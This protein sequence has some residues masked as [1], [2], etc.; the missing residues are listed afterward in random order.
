MSHE[1]MYRG[2]DFDISKTF[3][4]FALFAVTG[5]KEQVIDIADIA[6]MEVLY[7]VIGEIINKDFAVSQVRG[8]L[9]YDLEGC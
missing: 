1:F 8:P 4:G 3:D 6:D 2:K 5:G 9:D 7:A